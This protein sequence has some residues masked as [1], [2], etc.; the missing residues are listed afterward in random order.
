[1]LRRPPR[2]TRTDTLFPYTTLFRSALRL[3]RRQVVLFGL[4]GGEIVEA[5][6]C[7]AL[8][9]LQLPIAGAHRA[10]VARTPIE[11]L[12]RRRA[13]EDVLAVDDAVGRQLCHRRR[14]A[15]REQGDIAGTV[16]SRRTR[17]ALAGPEPVQRGERKSVAEGNGGAGGG[18]LRGRR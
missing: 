5:G 10:I 8:G 3:L 1:M 18:D 12:A 4:V 6:L 15:R 16:P 7:G 13:G 2:S 17:R 14:P 9:H 11:R